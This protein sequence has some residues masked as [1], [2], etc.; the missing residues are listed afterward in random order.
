MSPKR[1]RER[2]RDFEPEFFVD[3]CFGRRTVEA[4]RGA[5]ARV[6]YILDHF[7][8]GTEDSAWLPVVGRSGWFLVTRDERQRWEPVELRAIKTAQVGAFVLRAKG[9]DLGQING[10]LVAALQPMRKVATRVAPPF[11]YAINA[12][13]KLSQ[14]MA[15]RRRSEVRQ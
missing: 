14:R 2:R 7:P 5:G 13:G 3:E 11:V 8:A 1:R 10:A 4:L 15:G 9:L 12:D 6:E